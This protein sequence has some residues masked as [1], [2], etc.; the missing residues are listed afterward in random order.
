MHNY[1]CRRLLRNKLIC[2]RELDADCA[3]DGEQLEDLCVVFQ[4]GDSRIAP[5]VAAASRRVEAK[6]TANYTIRVFGK[7]FCHLNAEAM[8][9]VSFCIVACLLQAMNYFTGSFAHCNH[10]KGN[11]IYL[12]TL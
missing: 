9:E 6:F 3:T 10:L 11:H 2:L 1:C 12:P 4:I 7:R 5:A 8:Y